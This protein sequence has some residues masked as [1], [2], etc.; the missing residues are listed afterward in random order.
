MIWTDEASVVDQANVVAHWSAE[1]A[2]PGVDATVAVNAST[3]GAMGGLGAVVGGATAGG[4]DVTGRGAGAGVADGGGAGA[5]ALAPPGRSAAGGVAVVGVFDTG[6]DALGFAVEVR[7]RGASMICEA[8][9][10]RVLSPLVPAPAEDV[11]PPS[12]VPGALLAVARSVGDPSLRNVSPTVA[13]TA[14]SASEPTA[15]ATIL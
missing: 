15:M 11:E 2:P 6:F 5:G 3:R 13:A 7:A 12:S 10:V 8:T 4:V 9:V 14:S 1:Q